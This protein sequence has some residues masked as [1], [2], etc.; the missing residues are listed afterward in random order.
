[1][2]FSKCL[3]PKIMVVTQY[4][5]S[6]AKARTYC[7]NDNETTINYARTRQ[8]DHIGAAGLVFDHFAP[9]EPTLVASKR[10]RRALKIKDMRD[11]STAFG[12]NRGVPI[13]DEMNDVDDGHVSVGSLRFDL[14]F[15][16]RP[17]VGK[18]DGVP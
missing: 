15:D 12:N 6:V 9:D 18:F 8:Q 17:P 1:M 16:P 5:Y 2:F 14:E 7:K 11:P 13:P 4:R 10:T 3:D